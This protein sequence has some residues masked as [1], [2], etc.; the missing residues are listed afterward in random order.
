MSIASMFVLAGCG[1]QSVGALDRKIGHFYP[2][3]SIVGKFGSDMTEPTYIL[4]DRGQVLLVDTGDGPL[5]PQ[6]MGVN[7][8]DSKRVT[9][10]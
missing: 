1:D 9:C 6:I 8:V 2:S 3:A 10:K 4:C 5:G 7:Y